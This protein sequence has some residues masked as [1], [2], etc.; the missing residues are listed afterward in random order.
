VT[1]G[2]GLMARLNEHEVVGVCS[3]KIFPCSLGGRESTA[4]PKFVSF[5]FILPRYMCFMQH[6]GGYS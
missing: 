5:L 6:V 3:R 2:G 4:V 1:F